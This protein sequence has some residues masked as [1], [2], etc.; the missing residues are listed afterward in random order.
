MSTWQCRFVLWLAMAAMPAA[1]AFAQELP[2][3]DPTAPPPP[4]QGEGAHGAARSPTGPRLESTYLAAGGERRA[5]IS[6]RTYR[7]GDRVAGATVVEIRSYEVV[8][9]TADGHERVMYL[10]P[11]L[12][13]RVTV[14]A[15][16]GI[17]Q[18][19]QSDRVVAGPDPDPKTD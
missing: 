11:G 2:W 7:V 19:E 8:L 5:V 15:R 13:R 17:G 10:F 1:P 12:D 6:G 18:Q 4:P 14:R 9:R 3:V 16:S